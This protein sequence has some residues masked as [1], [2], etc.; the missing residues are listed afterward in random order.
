MQTL[1]ELRRQL[2]AAGIRPRRRLGQNFLIDANLLAALLALAEPSPDACVLEVGA[3]T[4]SLTEELL[5]H[6]RRVVAVEA[7]R[8]LAELLR[9]RLGERGN[10]TVIVGDALAGKHALAPAVLDALDERAQLV[11]N[12]PYSI[13]TPLVALCLSASWHAERAADGQAGAAGPPRFDRLTFTVQQ[14]VADRLL[15][16]PGSGAYGPISVLVALLARGRAGPAVPATAFWPRPKVASRMVRLDYDP[17]AAARLADLD[18]LQH[19][20]RVAFAQRRKQLGSL[21]KRRDAPAAPGAL[22]AA[23][24]AAGIAPAGRPADVGPEQ[25]RALADALAEPGGA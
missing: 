9:K 23:F 25:Y 18:A 19:V 11:A 15:A 3:A 13:A 5:E 4:G 22:D 6:C 10:L 8:R 7:D 2:V 21:R 16:G 24:A 20:L 1:R 17:A 12:L 14:E